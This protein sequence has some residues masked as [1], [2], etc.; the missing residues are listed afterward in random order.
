M[1]CIASVRDEK[2]SECA[3]RALT[4]ATVKNLNAD[5]SGGPWALVA[6]VRRRGALGRRWREIHL[7]QAPTVAEV[8]YDLAFE[9]NRDP[10]CDV[11]LLAVAPGVR[12]ELILAD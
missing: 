11:W 4:R 2:D 10:V 6:M 8:R 9:V 1:T 7:V 3:V 12:P 5:R